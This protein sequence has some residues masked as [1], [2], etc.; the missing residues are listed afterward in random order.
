[1]GSRGTGPTGLCAGGGASE[2]GTGLHPVVCASGL[3]VPGLLPRAAPGLPRGAMG[4]EMTQ[5]EPE[6]L[7]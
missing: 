2:W 7:G 1:M 4:P 5:P 3:G 6:R